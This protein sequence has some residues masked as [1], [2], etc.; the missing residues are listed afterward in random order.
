MQFV[1]GRWVSRRGYFAMARPLMG[2][3]GEVAGSLWGNRFQRDCFRG[4]EAMWWVHEARRWIVSFHSV[5]YHST[6]EHHYNQASCSL[7][8]NRCRHSQAAS[9]TLPLSSPLGPTG[10]TGAF[11][12][13]RTGL[14]AICLPSLCPSA[15]SPSP[16]PITPHAESSCLSRSAGLPSATRPPSWAGQGSK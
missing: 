11:P 15:C 2:T 12:P 16:L 5:P 13:F 10:F 1:T 6:W 8:G 14:I 3:G 9:R 4:W 7:A